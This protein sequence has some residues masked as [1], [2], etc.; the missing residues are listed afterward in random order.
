MAKLAAAIVGAALCVAPVMALPQAGG[1]LHLHVIGYDDQGAGQM[2]MTY[3]KR[4]D[5]DR[6]SVGLGPESPRKLNSHVRCTSG[7]A[8]GLSEIVL[9]GYRVTS[10][11]AVGCGYE[12][13]GEAVQRILDTCRQKVGV[14]C[15]SSSV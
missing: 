9:T 4:A 15:F 7:W 5:V 11:T 12:S 2:R 1:G 3:S 6:R 13:I 8:I 14:G 10:Y